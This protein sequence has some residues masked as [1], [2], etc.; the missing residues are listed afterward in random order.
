MNFTF[1]TN[2]NQKATTT[3]A[4]VL[5]K[6]LRRKHSKR[7]HIFGWI[8]MIFALLL[9]LPIGDRV[10]VFDM[11]TIVTYLVILVLFAVLIFEDAINGY[12]A[13]K[14]MLNGTDK[15]KVTFQDDGYFSETEMGNTEWKYDKIGLI[16]ET[17][18]YFVFIF[19]P[20][21]AQLYDKHS[22]SGGTLEGFKTFIQDKTKKEMIFV[23]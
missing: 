8:V 3:M 10:F 9:T 14:R 20:S 11:K 16:A 5:R 17:K 15:S 18:D 1:E 19:S 21:H 4:R 22:I 6:T 13:R 7:S 2:Y 12:I 23:K